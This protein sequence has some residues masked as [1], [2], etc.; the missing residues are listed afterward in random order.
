VRGGDRA[1][2]IEA[3]DFETFGAALVSKVRREIT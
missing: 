2:V 1:F 3:N